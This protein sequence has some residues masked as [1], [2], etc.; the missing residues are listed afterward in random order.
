MEEPN[1][2]D[3]GENPHCNGTQGVLKGGDG[4]NRESDTAAVIM[5][6]ERGHKA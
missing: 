5:D 6:L 3:F 2:A 4:T 1:Q